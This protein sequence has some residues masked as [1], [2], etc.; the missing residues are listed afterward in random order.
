M[1]TVR[2]EENIEK[3]S[4]ITNSIFWLVEKTACLV[5]KKLLQRNNRTHLACRQSKSSERKALPLKIRIAQLAME[6]RKQR[7]TIEKLQSEVCQMTTEVKYLLEQRRILKLPTARYHPRQKL[8]DVLDVNLETI[9]EDKV[10]NL[11][12]IN[13]RFRLNEIRKEKRTASNKIR[14]KKY[15]V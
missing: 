9:Y 15:T 4:K 1:D 13:D 3:P 7:A 6:K 5:S 14:V 10:L 2:S 8:S 12:V 11:C